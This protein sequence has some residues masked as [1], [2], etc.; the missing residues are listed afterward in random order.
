MNECEKEVASINLSNAIETSKMGKYIDEE[1]IEKELE[2]YDIQSTSRP[3]YL[4]DQT[5]FV[6]I[7]MK[8]SLIVF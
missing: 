2:N 3:S 5:I 8:K 7:L 1:T 4:K 6:N